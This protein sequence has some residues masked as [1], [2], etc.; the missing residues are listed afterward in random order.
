MLD[1]RY[2]SDHLG[3]QRSGKRA[4]LAGGH[5][6]GLWW[7]QRYR[8]RERG[9][10]L[11]KGCLL[12][13]SRCRHTARSV[14]DPPYRYV[15][16][17]EP[18]LAKHRFVSFCFVSNKTHAQTKRRCLSAGGRAMCLNGFEPYTPP[19]TKLQ[20]YPCSKQPSP[21]EQFTI[22]SNGAKANHTNA[23]IVSATPVFKTRNLPRH[24]LCQARLGTNARKT[25]Q[26]R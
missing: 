15:S 20:I 13:V 17:P 1:G 6:A 14:V 5:P 25:Q 9:A 23:A 4:Q 22:A 19:N 24:E 10:A 16:S 2:A 18:V 8:R 11:D 7:R 26:I 21:N 12:E 3:D